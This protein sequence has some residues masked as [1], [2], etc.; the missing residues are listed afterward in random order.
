MEYT[1]R[2]QIF[3]FLVTKNLDPETLDAKGQPTQ[4]TQQA[5]LISFDYKVDNRDY[6]TV[7]LAFL[8][9]NKLEIYYSQALTHKPLDPRQD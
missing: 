2:S 8:D 3:D 6:G 4:D 9:E 7:V 5:D 1:V